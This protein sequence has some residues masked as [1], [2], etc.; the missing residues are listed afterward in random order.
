[1]I[2]LYDSYLCSFLGIKYHL[3]AS[4]LAL[5][6]GLAFSYFL[7]IYSSNLDIHCKTNWIKSKC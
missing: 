5:P 4:Y 1:M 2:F 3:I 7:G 6:L